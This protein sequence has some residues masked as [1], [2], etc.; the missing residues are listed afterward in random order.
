MKTTI[1]FNISIKSNNSSTSYEA[2]QRAGLNPVF[3]KNQFS[4]VPKLQVEV[5]KGSE[6]HEI[7]KSFL[8]DE[9]FN[10]SK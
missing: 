10:T 8:F 1:Q 9:N 3:S 7:A 6:D 5:L 4:N 2:L